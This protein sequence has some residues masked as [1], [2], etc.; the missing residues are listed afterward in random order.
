M[1]SR[2]AGLRCAESRSPTDGR[3]TSLAPC[4]ST[5]SSPGSA[6]G[7]ADGRHSRPLPANSSRRCS[8]LGISTSRVG[9]E[10]PGRDGPQRELGADVVAGDQ[11]RGPATSRQKPAITSAS[12]SGV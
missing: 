1:R 5:R 10:P 6:P 2:A 4:E 7:A 11:R 12:Q 9:L 8:R 3:N